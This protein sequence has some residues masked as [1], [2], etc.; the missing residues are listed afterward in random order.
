MNLFD[1]MIEQQKR[2][3]LDMLHEHLGVFATDFRPHANTILY[4]TS[5]LESEFLGQAELSRDEKAK[6]FKTVIEFAKQYIE[7]VDQSNMERKA[8]IKTILEENDN[9]A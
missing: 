6:L 1:R 4:A 2:E 8:F 7:F 3:Y 5:L 9:D